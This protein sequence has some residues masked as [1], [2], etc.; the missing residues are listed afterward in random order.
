[1]TS[2]VEWSVSSRWHHGYPSPCR[3]VIP[4]SAGRSVADACKHGH[5]SAHDD[6]RTTRPYTPPGF[7]R[8]G[9][10]SGARCGRISVTIRPIAPP[11]D[12]V[13]LSVAASFSSTSASISIRASNCADFFLHAVRAD[14]SVT[15]RGPARS[16]FGLCLWEWEG[17]EVPHANFHWC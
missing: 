4:V 1:M 7:P 8:P 14:R 17:R 10:R 15:E 5:V 16:S 11:T 3:A 2:G 6:R 12:S 9:E 13:Y